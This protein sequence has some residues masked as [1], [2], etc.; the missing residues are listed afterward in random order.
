MTETTG[1]NPVVRLETTMGPI[2]A[3][4]WPDKAPITVANFLTYVKEGFYDGLIFHRAT[5]MFMVQTGGF[6][7]GMVYRPPTHPPIDNE[8][9]NGEKNK[10]GTLAMA[11]A[12]PIKSA[13][14]QFFIN[15]V[16]NPKLD[17]KGPEPQNYG[18]AV[19]GQVIEGM[20]TVERMTTVKLT[21]R[22][23]HKDVP[24]EDI[25]LIRAIV[26]QE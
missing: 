10:R 1:T 11:R 24:L 21:V 19:F 4:L 9:A 20:G 22:E 5:P 2:K 6:E 25:K 26:E 17:H 18:Y 8:A 7:P 12:F 23:N 16:D 3:E 13:A 15:L 14:A